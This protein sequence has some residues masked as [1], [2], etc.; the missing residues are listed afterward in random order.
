MNRNTTKRT[1][2]RV[3]FRSQRC[4][5]LG[6][7]VPSAT[8]RRLLLRSPLHPRCSSRV[9]RDRNRSDVILHN[10]CACAPGLTRPPSPAV[11]TFEPS[12][13]T[14]GGPW[15][16]IPFTQN[17]TKALTRFGLPKGTAPYSSTLLAGGSSLL[18]SSTVGLC[19]PTKLL[20]A[21]GPIPAP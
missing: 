5:P 16:R 1:N 3:L 12:S 6:G 15:V 11:L 18:T 20:E 19:P 17:P 8:S 10:G 14:G 9:K 13:G 7:V 4:V 2:N 21:S